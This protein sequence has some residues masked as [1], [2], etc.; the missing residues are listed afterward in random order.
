MNEQPSFAAMVQI[1][2]LRARGLSAD[3]IAERLGLT[4]ED[5]QSVLNPPPKAAP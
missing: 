2:S 4:V 5:V 3:A 1:H